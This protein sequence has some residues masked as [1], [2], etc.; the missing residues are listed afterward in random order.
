MKV[1][2]VDD[3]LYARKALVKTIQEWDRDA[4][5]LD[6]EDG[7]AAV[8]YIKKEAP[9]IIFT[10]IRMPEMDG[11]QLCDYIRKSSPS[12]HIVVVSGYAEFEYAQKAIQY[13]VDRYLLKPVNCEKLFFLMDE[14]AQQIQ[15]QFKQHEELISMKN[16]VNLLAQKE[17]MNRLL[18]TSDTDHKHFTSFL[19]LKEEP[20]GF[21]VVVIQA[22]RDFNSIGKSK[23]EDMVE[24]Y[25]PK[26]KY[27]D[28]NNIIRQNEWV[29]ASFIFDEVEQESYEVNKQI[30]FLIHDLGLQLGMDLFAGISSIYHDASMIQTAYKEAKSALNHKLLN[31]EGRVFCYVRENIKYQP[32]KVLDEKQENLLYQKLLSKNIDAV[33]QHI[34]R[35]FYNCLQNKVTVDDIRY[36]YNKAISTINRVVSNNNNNNEYADRIQI[37]DISEFYC[38]ENLVDYLFQYVD[39]SFGMVADRDIEQGDD[40]IEDIKRYVEENYYHFVLLKVLA[41]E[42]YFLNPEYLS[43]LFKQKTGES[44]SRYLLKVRMEKAQKLIEKDELSISDIST[45]VGY[46]S[47]SHFI[48]S[49][50][51]FYG[52]TPGEGKCKV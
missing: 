26:G 19:K 37:K 20:I 13:G 32:D 11:L 3:E 25:L 31:N 36:L 52:Y 28:F 44:F 51:K 46:N 9:D 2:V 49:Y 23:K 47:V 7:I 43:R 4:L 34:R 12:A 33:K 39:E 22:Q 14:I 15:K 10:D 30:E 41:Q 6:F 5:V 38:L 40:V 48:Q 8:E 42:K 16:R 27:F 18:Y 21:A 24:Q 50:K 1:L 29:I 45:L 17:E 35:L